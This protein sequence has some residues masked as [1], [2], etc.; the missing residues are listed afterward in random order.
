MHLTCSLLF[1][2][3]HL[4]DFQAFLCLFISRE[5]FVSFEGLTPQCVKFIPASSITFPCRP[6]GLAI[7]P[8]PVPG[9]STSP[10]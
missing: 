5:E 1:P 2:Y 6:C 9:T 10:S 3:K 4:N 8:D 7:G